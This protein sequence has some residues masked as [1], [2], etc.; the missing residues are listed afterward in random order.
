M[1]PRSAAFLDKINSGLS[2]PC[3]K[4]LFF[5]QGGAPRLMAAEASWRNG[6]AEDCKSFYP[7]SIPGEASIKSMIYSVIGTRE[8]R[9]QRNVRNRRGTRTGERRDSAIRNSLTG[10]AV[11]M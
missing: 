2:T 7:G 10:R 9:R 11:M 6:Y 1:I 4:T 5:V 3:D 8:N